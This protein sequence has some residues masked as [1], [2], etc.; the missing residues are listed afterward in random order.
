VTLTRLPG[1]CTQEIDKKSECDA[2]AVF[3][4]EDLPPAKVCLAGLVAR[5]RRLPLLFLQKIDVGGQY[6]PSFGADY[7]TE[8]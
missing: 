1:S 8:T 2:L 5:N 7:R 4:I 6:K 3:F